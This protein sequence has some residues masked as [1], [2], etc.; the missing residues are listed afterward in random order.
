VAFY[1]QLTIQVKRGYIQEV[2]ANGSSKTLPTKGKQVAVFAR[3]AL[4]HK[5]LPG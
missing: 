5:K 2:E 3:I 1:L 4:T